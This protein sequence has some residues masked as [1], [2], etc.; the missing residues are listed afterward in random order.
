MKILKYLT[1]VFITIFALSCEK[2]KLEYPSYEFDDT[3]VMLQIHYFNPV[4]SVAANY[5]NKVEINGVIVT[6]N[7]LL[8]YNGIP[9][10]ATGKFL[11][12]DAGN[13][14]IKFSKGSPTTSY[15]NV[16]DQS[17]LLEGGKAYNVFVYDFN[18]PPAVVNNGY[19]YR[20]NYP[21]YDVDSCAY[22]KFYNFYYDSDGTP[23][24][25]NGDKLQLQ[26]VYYQTS[27]HDANWTV[28]YPLTDTFT[29]GEPIGFG[30]GT[31]WVPLSIHKTYYNSS[32][33]QPV[34][35]FIR[36]IRA[37]GTKEWVPYMS[38]ATSGQVTWASEQTQYIG[39]RYHRFLGGK[40][41]AGVY[42]D[43]L[44]SFSTWTAI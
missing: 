7:N 31:E 2:H 9:D 26:Y 25:K 17:I 24:C 33:Y 22:N 32:G 44:W 42:A 21:G 30:E 10:G 4:T 20:M 35:F 41:G 23:L 12:A 1:V 38:S 28:Q 29:I 36:L 43:Q 16:Y 19:P 37:D 8:P 18:E 27:S 5:I 14:N 13:V 15:T 6:L 34:R 40:S 39:R 3:K 11:V